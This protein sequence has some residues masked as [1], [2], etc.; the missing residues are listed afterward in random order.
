MD[1]P[2]TVPWEANPLLKAIAGLTLWP[3]VLMLIWNWQFV[4]LG[5]PVIG[6]WNA[7]WIIILLDIAM[8]LHDVGRTQTEERLHKSMEETYRTICRVS[9]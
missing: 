4:P 5:A 9:P 1:R 8:A 2:F 3:W 7:L 6:F